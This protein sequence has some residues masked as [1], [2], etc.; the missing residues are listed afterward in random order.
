MPLKYSDLVDYDKL[1]PVK[2]AALEKF[3]STFLH[4]ERLNIKIM[5]VGESAAVLNF[6]D[7]DFMIAFNV[8]GL[9]TKNTISDKMYNELEQKVHIGERMNA[10]S[11]YRFIGQ[12]AVAM[13]LN[14]LVSVGAD[15]IAYGDF[16]TS[17]NSDWFELKRVNELLEG[18][19]IAADMA[20]CAIPCGETPT[21]PDIVNPD[22]LV[23]EGASV[24]LIRPKERFCYGQKISA[25]DIIYGLP[26]G[27]PCANGISKMRRIASKLPEGYFTK[28]PNGKLL[29]SE[30]LTPT[31]IYVRAIIEMFDEADLHYVSPIT[32]HAWEKIGR[33]RF[34]FSYVIETLPETPAIFGFL[35]EK[36]REHGFDVSDRENY[37]VWNMGTSTALIAPASSETK[38]REISRKHGIE[39]QELGRVVKGERQVIMPFSENGKQVVYTP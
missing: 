21:L 6:L 3:K 2:R 14:D 34:P 1:D 5:P 28:M 15:P 33:A 31:P 30:M 22:T 9:G 24:G 11:V 12:D 13:S 36:G 16:L 26:S 35:I 27:G 38:M 17:G 8:E 20:G 37:F 19:K 32:G 7:Y 18:Y 29:G 10:A 4:P 39:L 25:G 23:L